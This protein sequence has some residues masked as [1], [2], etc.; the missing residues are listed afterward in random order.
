MSDY[1]IKVSRTGFD[2]NTAS[3]KQLA[4]SSQWPLLP[5]E[6]EGETVL[7]PA[8]G[9]GFVLE[10]IYTHNLGYAPVF[11]IDRLD[12]NPFF[13]PLWAWCNTTKIWFDGYLDE[14]ITIRWKV[15]RRPI[16]TNFSSVNVNVT[17]ATQK[18]DADYGVL[19]SLPGK[20]IES[21]DK[22]DFCIRSDVRQLMVAKSGYIA[23][24]IGGLTTDHNLGYKAMYL[25]Y[26]GA[27]EYDEGLGEDVLIPNTYRLGSE[28]DDFLLEMTTTTLTLT[29]YGF[30]FPPLAYIIFKDTLK[31]NG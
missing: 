15:Y 9:G 2:V 13:F 7:T 26:V 30:P 18:I 8:P 1:G 28:A 4:F 19:V 25:A 5:I 6:A 21:T 24:G 20:N 23:E 27:Y 16:E 22:R 14:A 3:D 11:V 12:G 10:D 17:D 31:D 29:L